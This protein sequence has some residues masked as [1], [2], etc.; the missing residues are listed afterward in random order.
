MNA[1]RTPRIVSLLPSATEIVCGLGYTE[2]LVGRS[3]ECDFPPHIEKLP[4]LT[5]ARIDPSGTSATI[6]REVEAI[7][8]HAVSVYEVDASR[9]QSLQPTHVI[10]QVQCDVCAVSLEDVERS[11]AE[12]I[13]SPPV[14]VPL[15]PSDLASVEQDILRVADALDDHDGGNWLVATMRDR[16]QAIRNSTSGVAHRPRVATL[17]WLDPLMAAGN[18]MPELIDMAGGTNLFGSAGKHSPWMSLQKLVEAAPDVI[19]V[20]PCGFSLP[21]VREEMETFAPGDG[22]DQIPAVA[23]KQIYLCDGNGFFNRPGPRLI[24]S[25]E[26]IAEILHPDR[27]SFGH[28]GIAYQPWH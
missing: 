22:W 26:I 21:K 12:W 15:N 2:A 27:V 13:G 28:E 17:E 18:W 14:L 9:L 3:H 19:L 4:V 5:R 23:N 6:H 1:E 24:E 16:M 11:L 10:T 8:K 20:L 7:L 25:L